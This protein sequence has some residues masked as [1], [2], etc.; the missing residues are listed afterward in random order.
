MWT[1]SQVLPGSRRQSYGIWTLLIFGIVGYIGY[2]WFRAAEKVK[3]PDISYSLSNDVYTYPDLNVC[4][5]DSWGAGCDKGVSAEDCV[6]SSN[7]TEGGIAGGYYSS[8]YGNQ[9]I[10]TWARETKER[11]WCV[12]FFMSHIDNQAGMTRDPGDYGDFSILEAYGK[13]TVA[14]W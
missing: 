8:I 12:T 11:G 3:D 5:Y 7:S 9:T 1:P 13:T 4:M 14:P 10:P 2:F 6:F